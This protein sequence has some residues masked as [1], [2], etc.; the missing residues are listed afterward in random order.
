MTA[1]FNQA[2]FRPLLP[3]GIHPSDWTGLRRL[4]VEYFPKS[5]TR[6]QMMSTISMIARLVNE[7]SIPARLWIGGEFLT[8]RENPQACT[9]AIVLVESVYSSLSSDQSD[10]FDWFRHSSL[11]DEH[12]C[13]TYG[14]VLDAGRR[15]WEFLYMYWLNQYG[16]GRKKVSTGIVEILMPTLIKP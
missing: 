16:L 11:L 6:P 9:V 7:A 12:K 15:D 14:I 3:A 10:F 1:P 2:R 5:S 13:E 4:C 8:E